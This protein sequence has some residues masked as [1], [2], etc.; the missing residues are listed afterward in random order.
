MITD[1]SVQRVRSAVTE[2]RRAKAWY[3][4]FAHEDVLGEYTEK[5]SVARRNLVQAAKA[6]A[7]NEAP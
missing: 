7:E 2:W 6:L 4:N 1:E 3:D 5:L